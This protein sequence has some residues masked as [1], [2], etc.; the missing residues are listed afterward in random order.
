MSNITQV[1]SNEKNMTTFRKGTV[2]AGLDK[3]LSGSGPF[4]VFAPTDLAFGRLEAGTVEDL[5]KPENKV[6]IAS[7]LNHHVVAGKINFKDLK[8]GA[9]LKSLDGKELT[10]KV[11][12]AKVS[13][14]GAVIQDRDMPTSNGVIHLLDSVL[15]N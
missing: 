14:N 10:V 1:V 11:D 6:K 3:T 5:L 2:A 4:T 9:K 12:N 13:I 7:L 8:D 15:K